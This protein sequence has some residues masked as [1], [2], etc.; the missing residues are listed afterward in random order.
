MDDGVEATDFTTLV[1]TGRKTRACLVCGL[2]KTV[3]QFV[4]T[5]CE[6]C[7]FFTYEDSIDTWTTSNFEGLVLIPLFYSNIK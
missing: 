6:N 7:T 4:A 5:G 1:P 3:E 2:I